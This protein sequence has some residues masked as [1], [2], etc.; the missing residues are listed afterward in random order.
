MSEP[1][2]LPPVDPGEDQWRKMM[3]EHAVRM[4]IMR[5]EMEKENPTTLWRSE[6]PGMK[7]ALFLIGVAIAAV[8]VG[9]GLLIVIEAPPRPVHVVIENG[10]SR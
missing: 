7:A 4:R 10:A 3:R 8:I 9:L 2:I 6:S 1:E 5:E